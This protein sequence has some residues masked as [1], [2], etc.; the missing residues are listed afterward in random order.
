MLVN[1]GRQ[2]I[3]NEFYS[4]YVNKLVFFIGSGV[5]GDTTNYTKYQDSDILKT[6]QIQQG[7][8][9][10]EDYNMNNKCI[11]IKYEAEIDSAFFSD[12]AGD[13][14]M[15]SAVVVGSVGLYV[16]NEDGEK[17]LFSRVTFNPITLLRGSKI[18]VEYS[19]N[20]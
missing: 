19:I 9:I 10:D 18:T 20:F 17:I 8:L 5:I 3:F 7:R 16:Q 11:R 4:N 2:M 13:K 15:S 12:D 6:S 1:N 14:T